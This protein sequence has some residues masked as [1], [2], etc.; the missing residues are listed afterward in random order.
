MIPKSSNPVVRRSFDP[1]LR[2]GVA[3]FL[4][5][6]GFAMLFIR[7][8]YIQ[9]GDFG[10]RLVSVKERTWSS[11]YVYPQRGRILDREGR[12]LAASVPVMSLYA[13]PQKVKER[14]ALAIKLARLDL[15]S[16]EESLERLSSPHSFV[17]LSRGLDKERWDRIKPEFEKIEGVGVLPE[18]QRQ[19][20]LRNIG[21]NLIGFVGIDGRGLAGIEYVSDHDLAGDLRNLR[22]EIG[23]H[24]MPVIVDQEGRENPVFRGKDIVLSLDAYVQEAADNVLAETVENFEARA[25]SVVVLRARTGEVMAMASYPNFDPN[26]FSDYPPSHFLNQAV[27]AVFE[28]GSTF[29]IVTISSVISEHRSV[30]SERFFC[31]GAFHVPRMSNVLRCYAS[32]GP[33]DFQRA[34]QLSCNVGV[35]SASL[36]VPQEVLYRAMQD[37][38]FGIESGVR[39]P[40]EERGLLRKPY[41]WS[42]LSRYAVAIGQEVA[43]TNIQLASAMAVIANGGSLLRPQVI[44][45]V[46]HLDEGDSASAIHP[47]PILI[48]RVLKPD[49]ASVVQDLL[50]SA[51]EGAEDAT[52]RKA[53]VAGIRVGG[54]TGTA[55]VA[56]SGSAG[57]D[58]NR[59][60]SSFVGFF[61]AENPD[62]VISV[63]VNEP[64]PSIG[65]FGGDVAAPA[66]SRIAESARK[67]IPR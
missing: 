56:K 41:R 47:A 38:G 32:H 40:G 54:K 48:R 3:A 22:V 19:Y 27:N 21:S 11:R 1:A 39:L 34:I 66:F 24:G 28:P 25:G 61:P 42:L 57:Y 58:P 12:V 29:K 15:L 37:F 59:F 62:L 26:R 10:G 18:Y 4:V 63:V 35:I 23:E 49:V 7:L 5:L 36:A 8:G 45:N 2:I 20:P 16:L 46:H 51:V 9:L 17:W 31:N 64:N 13:H 33:V 55:Q 6:A 53:K 50:V 67:L 43:V 30:L 65:H 14:Q 52:G 44:L 60:V